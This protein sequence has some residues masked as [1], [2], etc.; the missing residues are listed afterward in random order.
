MQ[1]EADGQA[2][3]QEAPRGTVKDPSQAVPETMGL[4]R[5]FQGIT[6][7][8]GATCTA[9]ALGCGF[10]AT[11]ASVGAAEANVADVTPEAPKGGGEAPVSRDWASRS[12]AMSCCGR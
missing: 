9:A 7:A 2:V 4:S 10:T 1:A 3:I 11:G 12:M 5:E 6:C 8:F